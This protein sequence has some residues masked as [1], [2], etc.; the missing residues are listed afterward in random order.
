MKVAIVGSRSY[1]ELDRVR[2][3][4]RL[5]GPEVEIVSGGA[6]GV[7]LAAELEARANQMKVRIFP[8]DWSKGRMAGYMRNHDIVNYADVIVAFWDG[9]SRGTMH[10]VS[11]GKTA[12]KY[13]VI[14]E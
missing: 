2:E 13:T 4:V 6:R 14:I 9:K 10:T 3:F 1:P 7:D 8:A 12:G 5:L 11:L